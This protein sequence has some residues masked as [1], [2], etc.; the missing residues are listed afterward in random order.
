MFT[1]T[2]G[3][4]GLAAA[5]G[6]RIRQNVSQAQA[7]VDRKNAEIGRLMQRIAQLERENARLVAERTQRHRAVLLES[8][9]RH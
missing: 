1:I 6:N 8:L 5:M 7:L 9:A 4:V 3:E 2:D